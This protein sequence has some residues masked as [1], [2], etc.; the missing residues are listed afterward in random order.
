MYRDQIGKGEEVGE[1][2][3]EGE[4]GKNSHCIFFKSREGDIESALRLYF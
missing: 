4:G 3:E 1:E 2:V